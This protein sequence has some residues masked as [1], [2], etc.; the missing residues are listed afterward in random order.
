LAFRRERF[1]SGAAIA[2][3]IGFNFEHTNTI[4]MRFIIATWFSQ[5]FSCWH[6]LQMKAYPAYPVS[7]PGDLLES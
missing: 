3:E 4:L 6:N 5:T 7:H 2:T 1:A